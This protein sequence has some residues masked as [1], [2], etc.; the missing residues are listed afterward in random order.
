MMSVT[1][2]SVYRPISLR[3]FAVLAFLNVKISGKSV[4][5]TRTMET[6]GML[7]GMRLVRPAA[8]A[9][10]RLRPE[11]N[12][13]TLFMKLPKSFF[14]SAVLSFFGSFGADSAFGG[15]DARGSY[16]PRSLNV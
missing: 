7:A 16:A 4:V 15:F 3:S 6:G 2:H 14:F 8:R 13:V 1:R 5:R 9:R 12:V 10:S 11:K